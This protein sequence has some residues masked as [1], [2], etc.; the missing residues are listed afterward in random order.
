MGVNGCTYQLLTPETSHGAPRGHCTTWNGDLGHHHPLLKF[1]ILKCARWGGNSKW[2]QNT[3]PSGSL[4]P[5]DYPR[6]YGWH[7]VAC[8]WDAPPAP[9][10]THPS[11]FHLSVGRLPA[12]VPTDFGPPYGAQP[13]KQLAGVSLGWMGCRAPQSLPKH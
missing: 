11:T 1:K 5:N 12:P 4:P 13:A 2:A 3:P 6:S 10:C 9:P 7:G 8:T